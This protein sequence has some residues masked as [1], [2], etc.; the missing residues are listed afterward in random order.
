MRKLKHHFYQR[1]G[2]SGDGDAAGNASGASGVGGLASS[3]TTTTTTTAPGG[4]FPGAKTDAGKKGKFAS[5][6]NIHTTAGPVFRDRPLP[7]EGGA[8]DINN[9]NNNNR[10][11]INNNN[12]R[13][14]RNAP[15]LPTV[16]GPR[17]RPP[18]EGESALIQEKLEFQKKAR[19]KIGSLENIHYKSG[20]VA[21]FP[22]T[23]PPKG[24]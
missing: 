23:S 15:I 20:S 13:A 18:P 17:W 8:R 22:F 5:L 2:A 9:N 10:N 4:D 14:S 6:E 19:A 3:A 11:I 16:R 12:K 7:T 21:V 1:H 24:V